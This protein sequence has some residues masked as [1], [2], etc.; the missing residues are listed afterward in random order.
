[1]V[2]GIFHTVDGGENWVNLVQ[3]NAARD[4]F[5]H[6]EWGWKFQKLNDKVLF[7]S[8]ENFSDGAILR[9][10]DGGVSWR[11]LRINDRQQNCNLEGIGFLDEQHGWVGG[12]GDSDFQGGFT[13]AT[14]DGG[15]NWSDANEVGFRLNR[16]RFIGN[17]PVIAYASGDTVYKYSDEPISPGAIAFAPIRAPEPSGDSN[18]VLVTEV[19]PSAGRFRARIWERFGREVRLLADEN[20]PSPGRRDLIWDFT[21]EDGNK[22]PP[23]AF[24]VRFTI[25]ETSSSQV[26]HRV[27]DTGKEGTL[28]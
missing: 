13:S 3:A 20:K 2:P 6:G 27:A 10:D 17:P 7:V 9:S 1:M 5:P 16:F 18:V 12:W 22:L 28:P 23:G 25:D 24:I 19:P 4:E 8:C 15:S 26:F 21:D 14:E 11:R